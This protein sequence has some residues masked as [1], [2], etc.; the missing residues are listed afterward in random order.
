MKDDGCEAFVSGRCTGRHGL[1]LGDCLKTGTV[2][3]AC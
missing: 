2:E 3:S 1:D